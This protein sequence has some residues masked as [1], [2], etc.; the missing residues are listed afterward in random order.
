MYCNW[1]TGI[2]PRFICGE[3]LLHFALRHFN[4]I[5]HEICCKN[6]FVGQC[7]P[8]CASFLRNIPRRD[9]K[10]YARD[11]KV[12]LFQSNFFPGLKKNPYCLIEE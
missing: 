9:R 5:K 6:N 7:M 12:S 8:S 1:E 11:L 2:N 4:E 3:P 10:I